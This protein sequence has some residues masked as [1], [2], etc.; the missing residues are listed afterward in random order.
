MEHSRSNLKKILIFIAEKV[1]QKE[2]DSGYFWKIRSKALNSRLKLVK[3]WYQY[4]YTKIMN[5]FCCSIPLKTRIESMPVL[6]HG[7]NGIFISLG[8][9]IG[10]NCVIF[11]Q[12]TIG[13]NTLKDSKRF[14]APILGD[15]VYI[16]AGAK[17]IGKVK[18]GSNVRIGANTVVVNDVSDN[19]TVVMNEPRIIAHNEKRDNTYSSYNGSGVKSEPDDDR[20]DFFTSPRD[21][22]RGDTNVR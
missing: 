19:C 1:M 22:S 21:L 16:G 8:A 14:G 4:K 7:L 6:P 3:Y 13:S 12:V 2:Y 15:N 20:V 5:K 17:I 10:K 9:I 11:Q 18:I